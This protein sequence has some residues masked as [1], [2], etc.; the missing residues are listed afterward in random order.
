MAFP[1]RGDNQIQGIKFPSV[2]GIWKIE[3]K[4]GMFA[5]PIILN[6]LIKMKLQLRNRLRFYQDMKKTSG[7]T[8]VIRK[9]K[10]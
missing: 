8:L 5:Y 1:I 7:Q 10:V 6:C 2:E 4:L 3:S 9:P